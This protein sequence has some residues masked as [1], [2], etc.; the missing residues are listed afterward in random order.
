[1]QKIEKWTYWICKIFGKKKKQ[2]RCFGVTCEYY[3]E[4]YWHVRYR[5]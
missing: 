3:T 2:C 1:M 5:V 4:L